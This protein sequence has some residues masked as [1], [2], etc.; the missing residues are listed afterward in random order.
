[1]TGINEQELSAVVGTGDDPVAFISEIHNLLNQMLKAYENQ[2]Y[3]E[4]ETLAIQAYLDNYEY[5]EA[6]LAE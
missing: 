4:A 6:P 5:I 1:M 3:G 2:D